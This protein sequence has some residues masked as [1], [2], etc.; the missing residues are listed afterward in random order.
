MISI[1][2]KGIAS[3]HSKGLRETLY[4]VYFGYLKVNRF[5]LFRKDLNDPFPEVLQRDGILIKKISLQELEELRRNYSNLPEEFYCDTYEGAKKCFVGFVNGNV[6]HIM[7]VFFERDRSR[8]FNLKEGE[9]EINYGATLPQFRGLNLY[10]LT[11][12]SINKWLKE[13]NYRWLYG[14]IH[15]KNINAI[16]AIGKCGFEK[17]GEI[18]HISVWRPRWKGSP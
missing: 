11:M 18:N 17:I 2:K 1:I 16:R 12:R 8:F 7:W 5:F 10:P 4:W 15:D 13:N 14:A 3:L 6:T 9:A